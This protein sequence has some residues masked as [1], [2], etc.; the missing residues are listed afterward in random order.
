MGRRCCREG[1][2]YQARG[3]RWERRTLEYVIEVDEA[4]AIEA[5]DAV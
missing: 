3:S 4:G 5:A 2:R 1:S